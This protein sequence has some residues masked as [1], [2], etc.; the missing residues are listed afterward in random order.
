MSL[1]AEIVPGE[2]SDPMT[3]GGCHC[4]TDIPEA[5]CSEGAWGSADCFPA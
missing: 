2:A 5:G 3:F 1:V 4:N